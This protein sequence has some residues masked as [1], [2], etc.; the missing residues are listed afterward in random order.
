[1]RALDKLFNALKQQGVEV[2][3]YRV[4]PA[5]YG[6]RELPLRAGIVVPAWKNTESLWEKVELIVSVLHSGVLQP[7][8]RAY[9]PMVLPFGVSDELNEDFDE[10]EG[11]GRPVVEPYWLG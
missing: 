5:Y 9:I 4:M 10:R 11:V 1:M 2:T 7:E 8:E 3:D 6:W